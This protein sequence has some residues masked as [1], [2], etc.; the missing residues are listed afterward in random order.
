MRCCGGGGRTN[1]WVRMKGNVHV[2][3]NICCDVICIADEFYMAL[4]SGCD[5]L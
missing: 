1:V 3:L 2:P 4:D 5:I